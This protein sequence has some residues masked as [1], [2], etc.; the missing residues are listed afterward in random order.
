MG[1]LAQFIKMRIS[2]C[3]LIKFP[4]GQWGFVGAVP[5]ILAYDNPTPQQLAGVKFGGRFGPKT[6]GFD[7]EQAARDFAALHQ[8]QIAN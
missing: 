4:S 7:T 3:H 1:E 2:T 6:R 5:E 8:C